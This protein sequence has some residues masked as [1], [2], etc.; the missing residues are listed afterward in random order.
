[1]SGVT[2]TVKVMRWRDDGRM[3][4]DVGETESHGGVRDDEPSLGA[5]AHVA[6]TCTS[7]S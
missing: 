7:E 1:M 6:K 4:P 3:R 5:K 2:L